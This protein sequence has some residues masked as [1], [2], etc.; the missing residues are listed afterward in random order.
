MPTAHGIEPRA[1]S[2][3]PPPVNPPFYLPISIIT[4]QHRALATEWQIGE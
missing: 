3:D 1:T 4:V 2:L